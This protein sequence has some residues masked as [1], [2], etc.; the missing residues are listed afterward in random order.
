MRH[1]KIETAADGFATLTLDNADESMNLVS[2]AFIAEMME[3]T[4]QKRCNPDIG[5]TRFHGR[6]R[7][8]IAGSG[9]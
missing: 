2:D 8:E 9:L 3:A 4:A 6:S 7:S 1:M 5:Q